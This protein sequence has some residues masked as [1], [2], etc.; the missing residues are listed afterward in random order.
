MAVRVGERLEQELREVPPEELLE[1][2]ARRHRR[3]LRIVLWL[4]LLG[5]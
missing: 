2:R 3:R 4:D 5:N 1:P